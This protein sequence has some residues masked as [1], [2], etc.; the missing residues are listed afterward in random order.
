MSNTPT[1]TEIVNTIKTETGMESDKIHELIKSKINEFGDFAT[2]LGAAHIIARE[3]GVNISQESKEVVPST[4]EVAQLVS[5]INNVSLIGRIVRIYDKITFKKK[6]G[7]EGQL[8]PITVEDKTG[9]VRVVAWDQ[10]AKIVK[11]SN[12]KL[13]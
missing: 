2:E 3:L 10:K 11:E 1:L 9:K 5:D 12:C 4:L 8:Q 13:R 7:A 6:D